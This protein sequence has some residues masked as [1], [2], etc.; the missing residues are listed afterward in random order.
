MSICY[1]VFTYY[2]PDA[3]LK[4]YTLSLLI[5]TN[6]KDRCYY[7]PHFKDEKYKFYRLILS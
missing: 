1:Y 2:V 5:F 7:Y 6:V 3:V 4:T